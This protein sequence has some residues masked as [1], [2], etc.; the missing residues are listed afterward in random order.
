MGLVKFS[1]G[2]SIISQ[3]F[4]ECTDGSSVLHEQEG[5][6]KFSAGVSRIGQNSFLLGENVSR[7]RCSGP[8]CLDSLFGLLP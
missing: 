5:S 4:F 1:A 8:T 6:A 2:T 3:N 7:E